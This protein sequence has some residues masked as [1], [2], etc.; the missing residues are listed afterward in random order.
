MRKSSYIDSELR[1]HNRKIGQQLQNRAMLAET[2]QYEARHASLVAS[3]DTSVANEDRQKGR[4]FTATGF[5]RK[6]RKLNR[7]LVL[8]PHPH[9][10]GIGNLYLEVGDQRV[11][12]FPCQSDWMPEW[13]V[14]GRGEVRRPD[15]IARPEGFWSKIPVPWREVRRGWR[16]VL[17]RLVQKRL[18][19]LEAAEREFGAPTDRESWAL[20]TGKQ[21]GTPVI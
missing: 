19:S 7:D 10:E 12:L 9:Q 16:T 21:T 3:K 18:V 15:D 11:H 20:L 2:A 14:M 13:S 8:V 6:L 17:A 4:V 1:Q 5:M